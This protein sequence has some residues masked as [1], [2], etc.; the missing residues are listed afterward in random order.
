[1]EQVPD[2]IDTMVHRALEQ[3]TAVEIVRGNA[4]LEEAGSIG[5]LL[6]Y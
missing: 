2:I 3:D 5:A 1:M 4:V 6:R